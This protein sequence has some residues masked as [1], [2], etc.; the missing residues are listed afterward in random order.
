MR[1]EP[2]GGARELQRLRG[3]AERQAGVISARQAADLGLT[4]DAIRHH[5]MAGRLL[6]LSEGVYL[7]GNMRP[8]SASRRWAALLA[9]GDGAVLSHEAAADVYGF[10]RSRGTAPLVDVSIPADRQEVAT[11]GVRVWRSRLLPGKATVHRGWPITTAA[12]TVLDLIANMRSPHEVVALLTDACRSKSVTAQEILK[13]MG[14][15]RRQRYRQL[16]KDVLADVIGGVE[17]VLEHRYLVKVERAH[18]LPCGRRQVKASGVAGATI[19]R[20]VDYDEFDTVVELD[21]RLGHEGSGRH[22]D[23]HRDNA[24]TV[25]RK[26][27]LRYGH[28]DLR[29]PC[30]VA[31]EV[32]TVLRDRGWTGQLR[33]CGL[34]CTAVHPSQRGG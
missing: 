29:A 3:F 11:P 22:R 23:R 4:N 1:I 26:A 21:G 13:A 33:A 24:S 6:R 25:G 15:R 10:A 5:V 18:G 17:S 14:L 8:S 30:E 16:V 27:T 19:F 31:R 34:R 20:D 12:D 32:A 9:S 2:T 7:T 28:A